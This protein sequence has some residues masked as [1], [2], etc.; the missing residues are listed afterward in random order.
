MYKLR[1]IDQENSCILCEMQV[2]SLSPSQGTEF[3]FGKIL[4]S[5]SDTKWESENV[6]VFLKKIGEAE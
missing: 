3:E 1:F 4:Y 6:D 5:V 2:M